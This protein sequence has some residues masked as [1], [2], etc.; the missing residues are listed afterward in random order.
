MH[1]IPREDTMMIHKNCGHNNIIVA[2]YQTSCKLCNVTAY[3]Y[4]YVLR[5]PPEWSTFPSDTIDIITSV[6]CYCINCMYVIN[7]VNPESYHYEAST[8]QYQS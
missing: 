8:G 3:M 7:S 1:T 6:V 5:S 2:S 4:I